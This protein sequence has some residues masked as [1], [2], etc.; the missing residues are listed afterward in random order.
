LREKFNLIMRIYPVAWLR[1]ALYAGLLLVLYRSTLFYLFA[2]WRGE[3]FTYCYIVPFIVFYLVWEKRQRLAAIPSVPSW[4]GMAP[5]LSGVFLFFLGELAAE[6]TVL[7]LSLWLLI[8][9]LCWLHLGW[10]KL[11]IIS[12]PLAF[13]LASFVPPNAVYL[14]LTFRMKLISS[15][16]GVMI[17]QAVGISAYR[18]GNVIDLGFTQLEVVDAC[19]GLR[20]VIPLLLMGL[21]LAHCYRAALWKRVLL[22]L[23]TI[24][25]SII[26]NSFR[27]ASVGVLYP[28][29]G[30]R[31]AE[32]FFHN[33]SGW[34]I[35]IASLALLLLEMWLLNKGFKGSGV[36]NRKA[37]EEP[38]HESGGGKR[39]TTGLLRPV[40]FL[41]A[42]T[43]LFV[44]IAA[45]HGIDSREKTPLVKKFSDLPLQVGQ[46]SGVRSAMAQR[47][48]DT[49]KLSDYTMIDY[50]DADG[51][52]IGLYMAYNARQRKGEAT[53]SPATC[54]PGNGWIFR[55]TDTVSLPSMHGGTSMRVSRAIMEKSGRKQLAYFWFPQR[56]RIL[57][58][59]YQVKLF[60]FWDAL[61]RQRTDGALVR[62]ITPVYGAETVAD[63]DAR[64]QG[65]TR[66]VVPVLDEYLPK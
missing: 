58:S 12:F 61:T 50:R 32:G 62:L 34:I 2:R 28:L 49:L 42:V 8:C 63:A 55:E 38:V 51:N 3:D 48:L 25:L 52:E 40:Q 20:Y 30:Q 57:T 59:L 65:F 43:I 53:H 6:F 46:W 1:A 60:N 26:T 36:G 45:A 56:G 17:L 29:W 33:F 24:P 5:L 22:V 44:T 31:V 47:F 23:S 35:F 14:P 7:F 16:L 66:Q 10:P 37:E 39:G 15:K 19:S 64:L 27:I 54:L 11:R 4:W 41:G 21:L 13:G 18:E 9:G